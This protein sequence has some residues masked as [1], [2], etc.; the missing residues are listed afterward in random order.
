[1]FSYLCWFTVWSSCSLL[2]LALLLIMLCS[3]SLSLLWVEAELKGHIRARSVSMAACAVFPPGPATW[4]YLHSRGLQ[5][6]MEAARCRSEAGDFILAHS[7]CDCFQSSFESSLIHFE[8]E[9]SATVPLVFSRALQEHFSAVLT[10]EEFAVV[11]HRVFCEI[12][13]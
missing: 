7:A 8:C 11:L 6:A 10:K 5:C 3:L 13:P 12:V 1:M 2:C 4:L 9:P